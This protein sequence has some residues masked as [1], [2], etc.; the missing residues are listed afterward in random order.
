M[1]PGLLYTP[2]LVHFK[3]CTRKNLGAKAAKSGYVN[4]SCLAL[5]AFMPRVI[6]TLNRSSYGLENILS[7]PVYV[8]SGPV[9]TENLIRKTSS[10]L[11]T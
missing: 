2:G 6:S 1:R 5:L 10:G 9:C 4:V 3:F 8:S 11:L 7:I